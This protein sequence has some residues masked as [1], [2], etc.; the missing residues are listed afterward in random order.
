MTASIG[1]KAAGLLMHV[2]AEGGDTTDRA[3]RRHFEGTLDGRTVNQGLQ[4][5][6]RRGWAFKG[7]KRMRNERGNDVGTCW[8]LTDDGYLW[9]REKDARRAAHVQS[10]TSQHLSG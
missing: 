5:L 8:L 7:G 10:S 9:M 4:Y 2:I 1:R 6:K 3:L